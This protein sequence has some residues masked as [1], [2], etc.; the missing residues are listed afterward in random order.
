MV[1]IIAMRKAMGMR[2]VTPPKMTPPGLRV[3]HK[4]KYMLT[5]EQQDKMTSTARRLE[6]RRI[7]H[8]ANAERVNARRRELYADGY[9]ETILAAQK[10]SVTQCTSCGRWLGIKYLPEHIV[11]KHPDEL[12]SPDPLREGR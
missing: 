2:I 1:M 6:R 8:M 12:P 11:R 3:N 5:Y 9:R 10:R 4:K 7:W